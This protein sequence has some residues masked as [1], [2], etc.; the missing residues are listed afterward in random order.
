MELHIITTIVPKVIVFAE[1][2]PAV[3]CSCRLAILDDGYAVF[4]TVNCNNDKFLML[5]LLCLP[6]TVEEGVLNSYSRGTC[7]STSKH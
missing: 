7:A 3:T 5:R 2:L 4:I 1:S 6:A